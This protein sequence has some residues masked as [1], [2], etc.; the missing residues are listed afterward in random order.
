MKEILLAKY[1]EIALK[2]L[3]KRWFEQILNRELRHRLTPFGEFSISSAQSTVTIE[4]KNDGCDMDG[5]FD[6][7]AHV[8]GFAAIGRAAMTEK[9]YEAISDA[10]RTYIPRFIAGKKTFKVEAKRS[11]KHFPL[12]SPEICREIGGDILDEINSNGGHLRVDVNNPEVMV[13]VEVRDDHAFIT[14]GDPEY[15]GQCPGA[16]GMPYGT[17][18]RGLLLL[19]GGIDSPVAGYMLAKRGVI[20]E[21]VHFESY[22][23][24][25]ERARNKVLE[26]ARQLC[27]YTG[28]VRVHVVSVTHLQEV[29]R[30]T[31]DE[32]YFTLLLRRFMMRIANRIARRAGCA[33]LI[34]GESI[35]QVASQTMMALNV[36]DILANYPV[37]RP[38]IGMD[39]EEIVRISRRIGTYETSIL[40]YED[41]CT[42]FTPKHPKTRPEMAKV[43]AQED[44][45]DVSALVEEAVHSSMLYSVKFDSVAEEVVGVL[46]KWMDRPSCT[47]GGEPLTSDDECH[48]ES[49]HDAADTD[50]V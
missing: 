28:E 45:L 41:C 10:A 9:T 30:D 15:Y 31:C 46:E 50:E 17:N 32:D 18:G 29:L 13:R 7:L 34:T 22:P 35:G 4:P 37:F 43:E 24:T 2:G 5:A 36:T 23:Y 47:D 12:K 21:A 38:C 8:F 44:K 14:A 40:P 20:I 3:N 1:G 48:D 16:G 39:K 49:A 25:S 11:D 6:A 19:S 26:L 27:A 33:A 42:V